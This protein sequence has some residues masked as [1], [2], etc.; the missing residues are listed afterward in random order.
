MHKSNE[1]LYLLKKIYIASSKFLIHQSLNNTCEIIVQ[2][3]LD[4]IHAKYGSIFLPKDGT[5]IRI[6]TNLPLLY[7]LI[8]RKNGVI[9]QAYKSKTALVFDVRSG[10]PGLRKLGIKS[11][12]SIPLIFQEKTLG[13]L[14]L[15]T[16]VKESFTA[17]ERQALDL[18]GLMASMAIIN[19]RYYDNLNSTLRI[20]N[21]FISIAAHEIKTPLAVASGYTQLIIKKIQKNQLPE[22]SWALSLENQIKKIITLIKEFLNVEKISNEKIRFDWQTCSLK[23]IIK[24]IA[25]EFK[26]AHTTHHLN[27]LNKL[28]KNDKIWADENKIIR[29]L[30]NVLNNAVKFSPEKSLITLTACEKPGN[31][32]IKI[33]DQGKGIAAADLPHVFEGFYRGRD[34]QKEGLGLGLYLCK[35]IIHRHQGEIKISS[36]LNVGTQVEIS[37][38][39]K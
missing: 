11:I 18:L 16:D 15:L 13:V 34:H 20:R 21:L 28:G 14:S 24:E 1:A 35:S 19:S 39:K 29:V 8:P 25:V 37:L 9:N 12:I 38:P 2:E 6:Y 17:E 31:F 10:Q 4:L 7:R 32:L 30:T 3:A 36:Q 22:K 5:L 33:K 26:L 27:V 23:N